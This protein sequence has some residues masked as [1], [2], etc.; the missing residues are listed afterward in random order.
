MCNELLEQCF[1]CKL[2][3]HVQRATRKK[4]GRRMI[5]RGLDQNARK[6]V[7]IERSIVQRMNIETVFKSSHLSISINAVEKSRTNKQIESGWSANLR[8]NTECS[9]VLHVLKFWIIS[10]KRLEFTL[11]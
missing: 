1:H 5:N 8:P 2:L 6:H 4:S 3:G 10:S 11:K 7:V 9:Q